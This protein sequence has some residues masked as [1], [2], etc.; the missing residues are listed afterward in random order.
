MVDEPQHEQTSTTWF[1]SVHN[2]GDLICNVNGPTALRTA[3][4]PCEEE[5]RIGVL[6][7]CA[8]RCKHCERGLTDLD[9]CD[10][11]PV[12]ARRH[13][14]SSCVSRC[15]PFAFEV[16]Q[17]SCVAREMASHRDRERA[18]LLE[19]VATTEVQVRDELARVCKEQAEVFRADLARTTCDL[20]WGR[21]QD[22]KQGRRTLCAYVCVSDSLSLWLSSLT[23]CVVV[24]VVDVRNSAAGPILAAGV[25]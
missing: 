8:R 10:T 15:G 6:L 13:E 9:G 21:E 18:A 11:C 14:R 7:T 23:F 5:S 24:S 25:L 3:V 22:G 16:L 1:S 12:P 2:H 4:M 17:E 20:G 19:C